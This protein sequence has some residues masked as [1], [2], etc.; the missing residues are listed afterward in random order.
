M[1]DLNDQTERLIAVLW[2][3]SSQFYTVEEIRMM[4]HKLL[5]ALVVGLLAGL[6]HWALQQLDFYSEA[7]KG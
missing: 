1:A 2:S 3:V 7:G 6:A 4:T 5:H